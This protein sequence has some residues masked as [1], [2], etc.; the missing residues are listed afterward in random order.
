[1]AVS[2]TSEL[3]NN[4]VE[5]FT[6]WG[7]ELRQ[8]VPQRLRAYFV[9]GSASPLLLR[10]EPGLARLHK[11]TE[12]KGK[13]TDDRKPGA[14]K[15]LIAVFDPEQDSDEKL[16]KISSDCGDQLS[17]GARVDIVLPPQHLLVEN[18]FLPLATEKNLGE[19]LRFEMDRLTPFRADQV[20]FAYRI[21]E[22][23]PQLGKLEVELAV[24]RRDYLDVL[25]SRLAV[26]GLHAGQVIPAPAAL[27][28]TPEPA[29]QAIANNATW[30][31]LPQELQAVTEA[32]WNGR[33]RKLALI[34]ALL[35]LT[36]LLLPVVQF[37]RTVEV[38]EE[39]IDEVRKPAMVVARQQGLL[40]ARLAAQDAL[41]N[42]KTHEPGKL[43]TIRA[44]TELLPDG[45]W[46]SRMAISGTKVSLQ[47]ESSQASRLIELIEQAGEFQNVVFGSSITRNSATNMDRY[48]IRL[49]VLDRIVVTDLQ[50][51]STGV[52]AMGA[53]PSGPGARG[54]NKP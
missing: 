14:D 49:N 12:G 13:N 20:G 41:V 25:L 19:V 24:V 30:N 34:C 42:R 54:S 16:Q 26:L 53:S 5:F 7:T 33:A 17:A 1:M 18:F 40:A 36:V 35:F 29:G 50:G 48:E 37:K 31:M 43:D 8:L 28:S 6:W 15:P 10:V 27:S 46:A 9:G 3:N 4:V 22:R 11:N 2:R 52:N 21:V 38:L 51:S 39:Q 44:I 32:A 47:G 23:L 45:T